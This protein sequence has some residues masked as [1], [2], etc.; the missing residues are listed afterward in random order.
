[1]K[2]I[3]VLISGGGTN[4]QSIIDSVKNSE[5]KNVEIAK[6]ISSN[7]NAY[8]LKR[9]VNAN[10]PTSI[11]QNESEL[12]SVLRNINPDLIVLAG[13]VKILSA[14]LVAEFENKI[15]NIHP[16][17]LPKYG[18]KGMYG[19]N[20][21]K[22]VLENGEK[23]TGATVHFVDKGTDTGEIILQKTLDVKKNDTPETLQKRVLENIEHKIYTHA[24]KKVLG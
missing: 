23:Q 5:L 20:V 3:V 2:K 21:H 7:K 4:L 13:Y 11:I 8:G 10:I 18:G 14:E 15:I 9:A 1:M 16:A 17:L 12:K 24:I 6:V 22:K 19:L